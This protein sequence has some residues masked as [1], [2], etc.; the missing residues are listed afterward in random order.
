MTDYDTDNIFARILRDEIP[1]VRVHEDEETLVFMDIMPRADGHVLVI[2][3]GSV[4][5]S[6]ALTCDCGCEASAG[7]G[8][9]R[10]DTLKPSQAVVRIPGS[11]APAAAQEILQPAVSAVDRL[12]VKGIPYPLPT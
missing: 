10:F 4:Y 3:K 9:L 7:R 8:V 6:Y 2:P 12:N 5:K 11:D 1:S